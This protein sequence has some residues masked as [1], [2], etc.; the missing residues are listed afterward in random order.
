SDIAVQ[1][2]RPL[3]FL[4]YLATGHPDPAV[5]AQVIG[6][7][8]EGCQQ[9]KCVL[10]GGETAEMPGMYQPGEYDL[11]GFA[12][13]IVDDS[14]IVDGSEIRGGHRLI[15]VA[16]NGLHSN[17]FSLVRKICFDLCQLDVD[18]YVPDLATALGE[19]LLRPTRIYSELMLNLARDLPV[20]GLA[21]ITGGG[22]AEN[23]IRIIPKACSLVIDTAAWQVPP[24]FKWLQQA[25]GV[26]DAEMRRTFNMGIGMVAVVPEETA[27]EILERIRAMNEKAYLIGEVVAAKGDAP[28]V[29]FI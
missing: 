14:K 7:I 1:G 10:I 28:R 21:H 5:A 15:G 23:I 27:Q 22:I 13:G 9:A 18:S 16:S 12:V 19:E 2:A 26:S 3:F 11:A 8:G 4:A 24:I 29:H 25:G 17:G 20:H 6:G